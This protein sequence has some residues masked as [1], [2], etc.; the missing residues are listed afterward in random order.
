MHTHTSQTRQWERTLTPCLVLIALMLSRAS[1]GAEDLPTF[2]NGAQIVETRLLSKEGYPDR[3]LVLWMLKPTMHPFGLEPGEPYT[4]P[5]ETRGS[6]LSGPTRVSLVDTVRRRIVNTIAIRDVWK[7]DTLDLPYKIRPERFYETTSTDPSVEGKLTIIK[8][9]DHTGEG[10]ALQFPLFDALACMLIVT[11]LIGF[12]PETDRVLNYQI[13]LSVT[14]QGK[15]RVRTDT[16]LDYLFV[17][18]VLQPKA[19]GLWNYQID[20]TGR[21]GSEDSTEVRFDRQTRQFIAVR[22]SKDPQ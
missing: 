2:P 12:V 5:D 21:G 20:Y 14:Y 7:K 16:W 13:K 9:G 10:R 15:T 19:P 1:V 4:C 11:T 8:L 17:E 18:D 3:M 6:Y 22:V